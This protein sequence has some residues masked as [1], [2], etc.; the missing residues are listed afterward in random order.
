M[1]R[2]PAERDESVKTGKRTV[3]WILAAV[4]AI[5]AFLGIGFLTVRSL[6]Y[7]A[8][9]RRIHRGEDTLWPCMWRL[10]F[11]DRRACPDCSPSGDQ[12]ICADEWS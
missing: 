9:T 7:R 6:W 5:T 11:P 10:L 1:R 8:G 2:K 4:A 3:I 12:M